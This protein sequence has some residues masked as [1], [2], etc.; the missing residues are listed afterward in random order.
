MNLNLHIN[1]QLLMWAPFVIYMIVGAFIQ[2]LYVKHAWRARNQFWYSLPYRLDMFLL[3]LI[4]GAI[5]LQI[6]GIFQPI[7]IPAAM[8]HILDRFD[9]LWGWKA[10]LEKKFTNYQRDVSY[11]EGEKRRKREQKERERAAAKLAA[12]TE[13]GG[14]QKQ[15]TG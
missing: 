10:N 13:G 15:S 2:L 8:F 1:R 9:K 4:A 3:Y 12:T 6:Q 7:L 14:T 5:I 11:E